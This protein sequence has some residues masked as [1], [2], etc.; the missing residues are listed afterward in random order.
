MPEKAPPAPRR[1]S[2]RRVKP[3]IVDILNAVRLEETAG[4]KFGAGVLL[5]DGEAIVRFGERLFAVPVS[6]LWT[7]T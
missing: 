3:A 4:E 5:Y 6:Q 7:G 1:A 2:G